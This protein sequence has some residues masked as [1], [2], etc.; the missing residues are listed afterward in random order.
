ML[1][2]LQSHAFRVTKE[3]KER[4][5]KG[6]KKKFD[7]SSRSSRLPTPFSVQDGNEL[8]FFKEGRKPERSSFNGVFFLRDRKRNSARLHVFFLLSFF[9]FF[10]V[11][12]VSFSLRSVASYI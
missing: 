2:R 10:L 9:S 8:P 12:F 7:Y 1:E 11:R 6:E 5:E 3:K 4:G